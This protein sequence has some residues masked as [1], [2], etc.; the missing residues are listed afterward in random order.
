V[1][2][3]AIMP[4]N[5]ISGDANKSETDFENGD[6]LRKES[7]ETANGLDKGVVTNED[8]TNTGANQ[9]KIVKLQ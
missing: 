2:K 9:S 3:E 5:I 8:N 4:V 7:F 6:R 1:I